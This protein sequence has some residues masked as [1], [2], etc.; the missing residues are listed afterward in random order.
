ML[1]QSEKNALV[2]ELEVEMEVLDREI[3]NCESENK[4]KKLRALLKTKKDLQR[5]YQRLKLGTN[6]SKKIA[7]QL[8]SSNIGTPKKD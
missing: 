5:Q 8:K 2:D 4:P 3:A 6:V 1:M 7:K